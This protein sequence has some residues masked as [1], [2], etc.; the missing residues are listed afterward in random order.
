MRNFTLKE[1]CLLKRL[2]FVILFLLSSTA[3]FSQFY[4]THYIAPAPWQ[5]YSDANEIVIATE[6]TTMVNVVLSKSDGT[7]I[8]DLTTIKGTPAVYRFTGSPNALNLNALSSILSGAGLII[9]S[10]NGTTS[11]N[12]RNVASDN[13]GIDDGKIKGNAAL[14]SFGDAGIGSRYRIGYYRDGSLGNFGSF[15]EQFPT[16]SIMAINDGTSIKLNGTAITT[17]NAGQSYLFKAPMGSLVESS[18]V[19]VM[20][21]SAHIDQPEGCGDGTIDQ[22]A[23]ES[24]LGLEYFIQRGKGND[25]AEQTT[26]IATKD[27]TEITI[28]T[29]SVTG[30]LV[31]TITKT[32]I[33]AG[34]FYT[35]NNGIS[36]SSFSASRIL[37]AKNVAVYSGTA[38]SCEV[39]ISTIAPV[40]ACGGSTFIETAKF[41][42]YNNN[43]LPY[44]G[45]VL[46]QDAAAKVYV[47]NVDIESIVG[48]S[49]RYQLGTTGWY[50][51]NFDNVKIGNPDFLSVSSAAKMT[52]S[53]VQ[54]GGGFSMA[55]F[56]SNFTDIPD[57]PSVTYINGGEC[58]F[59]K[60]ELITPVGFA[61]YQWYFNGSPLV[62]ETSNTHTATSTGLYSVESTLACGSRTQSKSLSVTLCTD[63]QVLKTVNNANP[64]VGSEVEFTIEVTNLG[65]N[66]VVGLTVNDLLLSGYTF[67][68]ATPFAGTTYDAVTGVWN[69][70]QL[71]DTGVIT[72]KVKAIVNA[73][74][75]YTNTAAIPE[76][77]QVDPDKLNNTSSVATSPK[78][79]PTVAV[80]GVDQIGSGTCGL[81][82]VTL[83][84]N[85]PTVGTGKWT[86]VS[87]T[88]GSFTLDTD[89]TTT[90]SGT[91]GIAYVLKWTISNGSCTPSSD[92][93]A[94][95]FNQIPST[96]LAGAD[97]ISSTTCGLTTITLA[98]NKPTVG[99]GK[100]T[101]VSG[102]GGSFT[103]DTDPTTTFSGTAGTAYI[104]KWTIS[105]GSCAPSND[106]V[107]VTFNQIPSTAVA[108][109]DQ[110]GSGTCGLTTVTLAANAPTVGIGKWTIFSGTGGSFTLDTD[111]TTTFAGTAGTAYILKWTIS[112]G[113]CTPSSDDVA[114]TFNQIPSTAVAGADQISSTTCGLITVTLDANAPTVGTGKWTI[115]SGTGGSFTLDT[116]PTTAFSGTAG[117]AYILKWTISNSSCTPSSDDVAVTFNQIPSTA[118]AGAD[119]ISSTTCGLTTV[120][121]AANAPTVGTG[122]WTIVSGT[123]G[124]F[125]LDTDPTTTFAG[126]AGTAYILKWTISNSSCAASNDDVA[127]T[128]TQIPT[129]TITGNLKACLTTTLT[130]V[131]DA[132]A[133]NYIWYKNNLEISGEVSSSL[134][135]TANGDY[136]VKITNSVS[137]CEQ[138]SSVSTVMVEDTINP[139]IA[140]SGNV[141]VKVDTASTVATVVLTPSTAADN[142]GIATTINDHPSTSFAIGT[143]TVTWTTTDNSGN[144]ASCTQTVTVNPE[145]PSIALVKTAVF[146]DENGDGYAQPGETITY[147]FEVTNTGN[148]NLTAITI[149][150]PL[151]GVVMTGGPISLLAGDTDVV[152]FKGRYIILQSDINTGS[153]TNQA[154]VYGTSPDGK[155]IENKADNVTKLDDQPVVLPETECAIKVFNAVS[156]NGAGQNNNFY[157][158]GIDCYPDNRVEIYNRWGVLVYE[159]DRYNN[160]DRSFRGI[161]EGRVT[162]D[163]SQELPVGTYFYIFKYK[164]SKFNTFE[165]S[166]YL[167]LNRK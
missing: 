153:V 149:S 7:K 50:L 95:T 144:I 57:A 6:S 70:G 38:Q 141:T 73:T 124:S 23:P 119:Q 125:T 112:N 83:A 36:N 115:V 160:E 32:L 59:D 106:D 56:F 34:D 80:A 58:K 18:N 100:W 29:F 75:I 21:T 52:I 69:I 113:S 77:S 151:P 159:S 16:Y 134:I 139:T 40:S 118:V 128:F 31:S 161:S 20:N 62:G 76:G 53:I 135:V 97:Q 37:A 60:A 87:G 155:I 96:A 66:N 8:T 152:S 123:G 27:N 150:D 79:T 35:F 120:T 63:L 90:F 14:T 147:S 85:A 81:T 146:N 116:D 104:L 110:I 111:P 156:V 109:V 48:I 55:G 88:G 30:T 164:D 142:C 89:P 68:D 67:V 163:R 61:P 51:I 47:N 39:D 15:G 91:A 86:I 122:K 94:V 143:T 166:G 127:V 46:L 49:S 71:A 42:H 11:I 98:A 101:I 138:I 13:G 5:Y 12:L 22:I 43:A 72:L 64:C 4:A 84:A 74:G 132:N 103:L 105:N 92:D 44:F 108:G 24:V 82:T 126:T 45:Y 41:T 28:N 131:T 136:K 1:I 121:L 114:V 9:K 3:A 78:I 99:T 19:T 140:C 157:I 33:N 129:A 2:L 17:L 26:V 54:Q 10:T 154:T 148:T 162:V 117:T 165:K 93:V 65:P 167:Y 158:E 137:L 25:T 102:T 133:A 107:A 145:A 130:A